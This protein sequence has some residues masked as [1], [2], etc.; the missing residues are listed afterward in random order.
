LLI[1]WSAV[2]CAHVAV[3]DSLTA[4]L[5]YEKAD[6][7][8]VKLMY[9]IACAPGMK[10]DSAI[11]WLKKGAQL[12]ARAKYT[13]GEI[14]CITHTGN[15][16]S[17]M[18][19]YPRALE[20]FYEAQRKNELAGNK[21]G[22]AFNYNSIG[23]IYS[24]QGNYRQS[25]HNRFKALDIYKEL[26]D[27]RG[28]ITVLLNIGDVYEKMNL[29]DSALY[30]TKQGL[31][32]AT[33]LQK[34]GSIS[35][36]HNNLGNIFWKMNLPD[37]A[38][39]NYRQSLP[40]FI[41]VNRAD[42][43]FESSLGVA[44]VFNGA[45]QP[46]SAT[47]YARMALH[48]AVQSNNTNAEMQAYSFL[49]AFFKT[50]HITDSAFIYLE[51]HIAAKDSLFGRE[52]V[53]EVQN[54]MLNQKIMEQEAAAQKAQQEEERKINMQLMGIAAFIITFILFLLMLSKR[55]AHPKLIEYTGIVA[56]LLVFEFI[57]LLIHP[58]IE[59]LTHHTPVY[60]LLI[61][62]GVAAVLAPL[63]HRLEKYVKE[64]LATRP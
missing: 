34:Q 21:S 64:K 12:A 26:N 44:R 57:A 51:K 56:L 20:Y 45:A 46:D 17:S 14:D 23:I 4:V 39:S 40:Y 37:S 53:K 15:I 63:H 61:L 27:E 13:H 48:Y 9:A 3:A 19:N 1:L 58:F 38:L 7:N 31:H 36:A 10:P 28:I 43:A 54:L 49:S 59:H 24:T 11:M 25:L 42:G 18:G 33:M 5:Q 41:K 22:I 2:A 35:V 62:M 16:F 30:Y 32:K 8:R 52:K 60:M 50:Q 55:K 29:P 47:Y 6:T